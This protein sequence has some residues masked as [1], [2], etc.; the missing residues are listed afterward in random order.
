[1]CLGVAVVSL[2]LPATLA[3]DPWAWLVWGRDVTRLEL[4]TAGGPS[5]KPLP[6][7]ATTAFALA[8]G[9]APALWLV[10]A[11]AGGLLALAG[12]AVLAARLVDR[13]T[14]TTRHLG[15]VAGATAAISMAFSSWWL[16]NTALGNSEGLL[17][18]A[19]LWAAIAHLDGRPRAA[20]AFLVA[21]TAAGEG[22]DV[23]VFLAG[24]AVQLARPETAAAVEGV[25]TGSLG[26]HWEALADQG[27]PVFLSGMSSKARGLG[28]GVREGIELAPPEKLVELAVWAERT[29]T[30]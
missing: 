18:A 30:Y 13:T 28:A 15:A 9:A 26:E 11:R 25:G 2:V 10:V 3:F 7:V 22:H 23:R 20:L 12:A 27:V 8:G 6:V 1:V 19:A 5:W 4:D 16:F 29:L 24:D 17:A 21:R 14:S